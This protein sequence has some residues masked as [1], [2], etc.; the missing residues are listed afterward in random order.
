M[1]PNSSKFSSGFYNGFHIYLGY[2]KAF[3]KSK[4]QRR[5][6][7]FFPTLTV[8]T[9]LIGKGQLPNM[10]RETYSAQEADGEEVIFSEELVSKEDVGRSDEK[11]PAYLRRVKLIQD[12]RPTKESDNSLRVSVVCENPEILEQLWQDYRS[13][14]LNV[15][16]EKCLLTD[17]IKRMFRLTSVK[18]KTTILEEDYLACK[19][20][21]LNNIG[22]LRDIIEKSL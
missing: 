19:D 17:D 6:S 16:A 2:T 11:F 20:S 10:Q 15:V 5:K 21:L 8:Q 12:S 1:T 22:G 9:N 18:L 14:Y 7:S 13:G 4:M 3:F